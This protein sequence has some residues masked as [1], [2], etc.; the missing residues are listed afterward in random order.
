MFVAAFVE[1]IWSEPARWWIATNNGLVDV[2]SGTL[3]TPTFNSNGN[4]NVAG[5]AT[6]AVTPGFSQNGGVTTLD[7]GATLDV[8][9]NAITL[10]LSVR[11]LPVC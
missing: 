7:S 8:G 6:L 9:A 2:Q 3:S 5:G 11:V 4:I 1:A 10:R